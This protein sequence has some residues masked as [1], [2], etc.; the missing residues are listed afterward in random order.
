VHFVATAPAR[1]VMN[2]R[3]LT[4]T[5]GAMPSRSQGPGENNSP[6]AVVRST[7]VNG[8]S[9]G[10]AEGRLSADFVAKVF[11]PPDAIPIGK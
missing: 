7:S 3:H 10:G 6:R 9:G 2:S 4:I 8:P 1:S 5:M 11:L